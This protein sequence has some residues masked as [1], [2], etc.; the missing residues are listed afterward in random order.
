MNNRMLIALTL[1]LLAACSSSSPG[2]PTGGAV[3]GEVDMHCVMN[4]E[5]IKTPVGAC[6]TGVVATPDAAADDGGAG[7]GG[8][9]GVDFGP[10]LFNAEADDDDCK[11]HV[12]WT[13]TPVRL[14][15]DVTFSLNVVKRFD[16]QPATNADVQI[17]ATLNNVHPTPSVNVTSTESGGGNYKVGPVKLDQ[18]GRWVVRFHF[19][20]TCSDIPEDSP[21]G[22]VAFFVEV[23]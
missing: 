14:D 3:S 1:T 6:M 11:Y 22:H 12:K 10:P 18:S 23:P 20:E 7:G 16:G 19:Y 8:G 13:S 9:G 21:H 4:D 2:G 17:D 5:A 15:A